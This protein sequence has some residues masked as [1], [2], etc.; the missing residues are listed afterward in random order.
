MTRAYTGLMLLAGA[1]QVM[2]QAA[3]KAQGGPDVK[4]MF[5]M[6]AVILAIMYFLMIRPEQK[7]QKERQRLI[8]NLKKGDRV[9][10]TGGIHGTVGNV[11]DSTVMVKVSDGVVLEFAK[12]AVSTVLNADAGAGDKPEKGK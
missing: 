7:K 8:G 3:G 1:T 4:S 11:K 9:L 12:A 5:L 10:T 2:A 6:M